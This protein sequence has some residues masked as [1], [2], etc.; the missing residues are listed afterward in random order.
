MSERW[1]DANGG[2]HWLRPDGTSTCST[3]HN[4]GVIGNGHFIKLGN[5]T[6]RDHAWDENFENEFQ[7]ADSIFPSIID[8]LDT[9]DRVDPP[10]ER[11][12]ADRVTRVTV[13]DQQFASLLVRP[14]GRSAKFLINDIIRYRRPDLPGVRGGDAPA[15]ISRRSCGPARGTWR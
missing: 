1:A 3:P 6:G 13:I 5:E 8:W 7:H 4:F 9:L 14:T 11:P 10:I 12:V 2:T 15:R